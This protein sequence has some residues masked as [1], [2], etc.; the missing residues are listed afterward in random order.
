VRV[1]AGYFVLF[2]A[3]SLCVY[4]VGI[5]FSAAIGDGVENAARLGMAAAFLVLALSLR[6]RDAGSSAWGVFYALFVA[7]VALYVSW[8]FSGIGN[9]A[10]SVPLESAR[11]LAIAK[12]SSAVL[13]LGA[14]LLLVRAIGERLGSVFLRWGN[15]KLGLTIGLIGF[16]VLTALAVLQA[17]GTGVSWQA[18]R[19]LAP[20]ILVFILANGFLEEVLFRGLFL[21]RLEPLVGRWPANFLTAIAFTAAHMQV[22]YAPD[23]AP[24]LAV[25]FGLAVAWGYLMQRSESVLGPAL[26]HAGADTLIMLQIFAMYGVTD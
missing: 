10:L 13:T 19:G 3:L 7:S 22:G 26:F 5:T 1:R 9:R 6:R 21:G 17:M 4:F 15:L 14:I 16:A 8:R 2:L 12:L 11:G 24:F 25:L 23:M 18:L 20:W